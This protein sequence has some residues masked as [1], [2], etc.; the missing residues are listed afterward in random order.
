MRHHCAAI[1]PAKNQRSVTYRPNSRRGS[2]NKRNIHSVPVRCIHRGA[3][4]TRCARKSMV[5]P[6]PIMTGTPS[7]R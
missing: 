5:A 2:C 3:R 1:A 7:E 6:T 4:F